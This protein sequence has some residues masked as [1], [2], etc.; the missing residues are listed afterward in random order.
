MAT[1]KHTRNSIGEDTDGN[2]IIDSFIQENRLHVETQTFKC[3]LK[4]IKWI[5]VIILLFISSFIPGIIILNEEKSHQLDNLDYKR[6]IQQENETACVFIK[7]YDIYHDT[8]ITVCNRY[9]DVVIDVRKF[10]NNTPSVIGI[11][12]GERQWLRL[13]QVSPLVDRAITEARTYWKDLKILKY[14]HEN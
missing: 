1:D 7:Q 9:G 13:K 6:V 14:R 2:T 12:I 11:Q 4:I 10:F 3:H 8:C 5:G